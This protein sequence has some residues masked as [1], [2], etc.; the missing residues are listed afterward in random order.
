MSKKEFWIRFSSYVAL[1]AVA[2]FAFLTWRFNLFSKVSKLSIGGWGLLAIVVI[3]VFFISMIKAIKKGLPFSFGVQVLTVI[4]KI[5]IPIM[6]AFLCFNFFQDIMA[7]MAQFLGVL[8]VCETAAGII[9][10][11]PQWA[12]ENKINEEES[13][14]KGLLQSLGIV[15]EENKQ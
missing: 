15:K 12:H 13:R 2:P 6:V 7:E 11:I 3:A 8:F 9:N 1:G 14:M 5:S 10:P 4:C